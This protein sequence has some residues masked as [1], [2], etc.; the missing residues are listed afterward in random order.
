MYYLDWLSESLEWWGNKIWVFMS[1]L[2]PTDWV[3]APEYYVKLFLYALP[4][5]IFHLFIFIWRRYRSRRKESRTRNSTRMIK[6]SYMCPHCGYAP[7]YPPVN[8]SYY[9]AKCGK[10]S[11][12]N[13]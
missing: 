13:R 11:K 4:L 10:M 12:V 9:C 6:H 2:P 3:E 7:E 5:I 1:D 8:G